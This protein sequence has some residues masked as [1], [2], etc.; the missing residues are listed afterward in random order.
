M[1]KIKAKIWLY[2][3][4]GRKTP[5]KSGYR[6]LF[7]FKGDSKYSGKIDLISKKEFFPG[8][9]DIVYIT[10]ANLEYLNVD[11]IFLF[12]EGLI[13]LGEGIVVEIVDN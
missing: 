12:S 2:K 5:F 4:N 13:D 1:L 10:F 3:K 9:E 7:D 8:E 11:N 6:P